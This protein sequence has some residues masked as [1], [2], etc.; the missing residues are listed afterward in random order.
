ME[1]E[2]KIRNLHFSNLINIKAKSIKFLFLLHLFLINFEV[3]FSEYLE[4]Y[5]SNSFADLD[6][7]IEINDYYNLSIFLTK[8]KK[9]FMGIPPIQIS[10]ISF[11]NEY[12][13][14]TSGVT[15]NEKYILMV[16]TKNYLLTKVNINTG[17]E[18]PLLNYSNDITIPNY[19]C[20]GFKDNDYIYISMSHIIKPIKSETSNENAT[21]NNTLNENSNDF[22]NDETEND[23]SDD[24]EN[25]YLEHSIIRIKL[26]NVNNNDGPIM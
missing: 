18:I 5:Q 4:S 2:N 14:L 23:S 10:N 22:N 13:N 20:G 19:P 11:N 26:N 24:Y 16:C 17:V 9:I 25:K 6:S 21:N 3:V 12:I 15:Y 7:L 1:K 8:N